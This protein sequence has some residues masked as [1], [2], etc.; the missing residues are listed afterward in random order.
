MKNKL[1]IVLGIF[2]FHL[3]TVAGVQVWCKRTKNKKDC[4]SVVNATNQAGAD[5]L[6]ANE[7]CTY[8]DPQPLKVAPSPVPKPSLQIIETKR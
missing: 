6:V 8:V 1:I 4:A 2:L 3:N 5:Y 7:G